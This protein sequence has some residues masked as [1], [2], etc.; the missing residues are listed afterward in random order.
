MQNKNLAIVQARMGSTR[1]PNKVLLEVQGIPLLEYEIRRVEQAKKI[2]KIIVAT[3]VKQE[4]DKIEKLCQKI[5]IDCFRGA[6]EDVLNRYY[7]CSLKY[8]DYDNILR[9]TGDCPLIDAKV[10]DQAITYFEEN[11]YDYVS[12][13][14]S[15]TFP[16]GLDTEIFKKELLVRAVE[17]SKTDFEKEH[18]TVA[19]RK[20]KRIKQ[21]NL[22]S[23]YDFSHIRLTLDYPEDFEVIKFL[24]ER[25]K[26]TDGYLKHISLLTKNLHIMNKNMQIK[27]NEK[28]NENS[29]C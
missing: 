21:G 8:P 23:Q 25:S 26:I 19:M 14:C 16:D 4:D 24:L 9:L 5:N 1:L 10:I 2:D 17:Q 13:V 3:T 27:R 29:S 18:V 20:N 22:A 15:P 7:Q 6:E 12:N 11:N 28:I